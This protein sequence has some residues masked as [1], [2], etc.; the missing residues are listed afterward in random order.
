MV[1]LVRGGRHH[2]AGN[3]AGAVY[4]DG[5]LVMQAVLRGQGIALMDDIFAEEEIRAGRLLR[6]SD[7]AVSHGAY[8]LAARSFERLA[9]PASLFVR[10][11]SSRIETF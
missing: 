10:W 4:A 3:R 11:I 8:W 6:L 2:H 7:L 9:P 1:P 5:G